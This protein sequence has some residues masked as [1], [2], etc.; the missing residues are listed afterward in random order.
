MKKYLMVIMVL[1]FLLFACASAEPAFSQAGLEIYAPFAHTA[2]TGETTAV[3]MKIKN[4]GPEA[5][6]LL[7]ASY[8]G[9]V[10]VEIM[11]SMM[12]A[13]DVM[14][15]GSVPVIDLPARSTVELKSGGYHI[16]LMDL[17]QELKEGSTITMTLEFMKAGK[18]KL[19][20]P[21]KTP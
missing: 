2:G 17:K 14:S 19:E 13:G 9:A 21:V 11:E 18:L 15:M 4:N 1:L 12:M 8:D 10:S 5:D 6:A 3:Y 20:V 7:K 16:M